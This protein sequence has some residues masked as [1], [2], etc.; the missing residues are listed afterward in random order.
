MVVL[1][2]DT[3]TGK[4]VSLLGRM[5]LP[6]SPG[7]LWFCWTWLP[8]VVC[9]YLI[10]NES[11]DTYSAA[12]TSTWIRHL[13]EALCGPIT[14]HVWDIVHRVLRKSGH[15]VGYGIVGVC[16]FRAWL[17]TWRGP[18][19]RHGAMTWY[20]TSAA[21]AVHCTLLVATADELHQTYI[22]SRT[23][24]MSDAWLDTLGAVIGIGVVACARRN[25]GL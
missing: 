9:L 1:A 12:H 14:Q 17:L 8:V 11:T 4:P 5:S 23:G 6:G 24:L 7:V 2:P 15:F 3:Q 21:M 19:L 20:R 18:L 22:P 13:A 10:S 16:W 25:R